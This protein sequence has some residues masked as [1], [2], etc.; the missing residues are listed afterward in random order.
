MR[1]LPGLRAFQYEY[2]EWAAGGWEAEA[3]AEPPPPPPSW[4]DSLLEAPEAAA[5]PLRQNVRIR[6][7]NLYL[8]LRIAR[9][10]HPIAAASVLAAAAAAALWARG[11]ASRARGGL[12]SL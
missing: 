4:L 2:G 11:R 5:A 1:R 10:E 8:T 9:D 7:R 12:P 3:A 6:L